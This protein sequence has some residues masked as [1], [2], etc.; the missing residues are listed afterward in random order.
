M[1]E[2]KK[3]RACPLCKGTGKMVTGGK[4]FRVHACW[5]CKG[6]KEIPIITHEELNTPMDL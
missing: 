5:L 3:T 4:D 1:G 2:V 6:T